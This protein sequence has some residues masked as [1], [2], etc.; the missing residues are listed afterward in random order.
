MN[1]RKPATIRTQ[2]AEWA[3]AHA[4]EVYRERD[5]LV[6]ALSKV[7]PS[8]LM[9]HHSS[10]NQHAVVCIHTPV[11]QLAWTFPDT[12]WAKAHFGHLE[13]RENDWDGCKTKERFE[14]LEKL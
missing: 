3:W 11:G 7:Y 9:R 5:L 1:P 4:A 13:W 14:R 12:E 10:R 2:Q 8:H 6:C